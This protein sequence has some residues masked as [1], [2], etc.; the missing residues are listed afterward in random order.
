MK[1]VED[2]IRKTVSWVKVVVV[3]DIVLVVA[4]LVAVVMDKLLAVAVMVVAAM[5][6]NRHMLHTSLQASLIPL[7]LGLE[8]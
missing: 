8:K 6:C 4:A 5:R 7:C 2:N 1:A 3:M